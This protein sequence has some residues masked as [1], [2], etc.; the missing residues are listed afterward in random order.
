MEHWDEG[1]RPLAEHQTLISLYLRGIWDYEIDEYPKVVTRHLC[2]SKQPRTGNF[3]VLIYF[4]HS[5]SVQ[6]PC[7]HP[8]LEVSQA[9]LTYPVELHSLPNL[10][11]FSFS[12][13][14]LLR[15]W[16]CA[17]QST[18]EKLRGPFVRVSSCSPSCW[19]QGWD[20]GHQAWQQEPSSME[21]SCRS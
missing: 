9:R 18:Q 10:L 13:L 5:K 15:V 11:Y 6:L 16:I 1:G 20:S 4:L 19:S 14:Y 3:P 17:Y 2:P 7:Q 12:Y 21:P 8:L